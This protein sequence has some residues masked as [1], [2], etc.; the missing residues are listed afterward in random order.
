[1]S[2]K[3]E[4]ASEPGFDTVLVDAA[5]LVFLPDLVGAEYSLLVNAPPPSSASSLLP[6]L[7]LSDTQ[8]YET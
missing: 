5:V 1:M 4:P 6:S 2:L 8:V 3:Y 7:E